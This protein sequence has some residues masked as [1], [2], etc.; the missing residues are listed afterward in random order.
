MTRNKRFALRI[1]AERKIPLPVTISCFYRRLRSH[2]HESLA[3]FSRKI[4][5]CQVQ[6]RISY[7]KNQFEIDESQVGSFTWRPK[8]NTKSRDELRHPLTISAKF[9]DQTSSTSIIDRQINSSRLHADRT[10]DSGAPRPLKLKNKTRDGQER[11]RLFTERNWSTR[12]KWSSSET[13][14][15]D[16]AD[17]KKR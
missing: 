4:Y 6:E 14:L 16:D 3:A 2:Y 13:W 1:E 10:W 11:E 5:S 7:E 15:K 17:F 9:G 8:L 12:K